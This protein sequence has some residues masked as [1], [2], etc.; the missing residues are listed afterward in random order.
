MEQ[1]MRLIMPLVGETKGYEYKNKTPSGR[2]LL[3]SRSGAGKM[4]MWVQDIKPDALYRVMLIFKEGKFYTGL[5]LCNLHVNQDGKTGH[6]YSFNAD[7]IEGFKRSLTDCLGVAVVV[8]GEGSSAPLCGYKSE[9]LPWRHGLKVLDR[10]EL[11][12]SVV[13]PKS[14]KQSGSKKQSEET[15]QS[16]SKKKSTSKKQRT[17]KESINKQSENPSDDII[18]ESSET[19]SDDIINE[20]SETSSDDIINESS[21]TS[22]DDIV[23]EPS[24]DIPFKPDPENAL[25]DTFKEEVKSILH[26]HTHM[27]PFEKQN[28]N[29]DWVRISLDENLSLPNNICDLLTEPFVEEAYR[30]YNHIILGKASDVGPRRYYIGIPALYDPKDKI[31]GFRQFKCSEDKEPEN[32]D[33]GYWL[34]FMS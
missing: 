23:N 5:H 4:I 3:E 11:S 24:E 16:A 9:I 19:S 14:T 13:Q 17:K 31:I 26:T 2:C 34:I 1:Y 6:K 32:G 30:K 18:N 29:V 15:D 22:S 21:E 33:Y 7:D 27:H 12:E 25:S 8:A 20:S 10:R 28:R